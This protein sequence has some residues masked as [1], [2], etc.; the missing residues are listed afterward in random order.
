MRNKPLCWE[1]Y[2]LCQHHWKFL[3]WMSSW[4]YRR[5]L[6]LH[7]SC[8]EYA[9]Y[10]LQWVPILCIVSMLLQMSMNV[11]WALVTRT[12][13]TASIP[14]EAF[15]ASVTLD[16]QDMAYSAQ[17][18]VAANDTSFWAKH[19]TSHWQFM[20]M[21][22]SKLVNSLI[23]KFTTAWAQALQSGSKTAWL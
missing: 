2:T 14:M 4:I 8:N 22:L 16:T 19:Y 7:R 23:I 1:Q 20:R 12:M 15:L 13:L 9:C 6:S 11:K 3:L 21:L 17:V 5:W 10:S 18:H